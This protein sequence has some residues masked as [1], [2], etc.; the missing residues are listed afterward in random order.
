MD[1]IRLDAAGDGIC[2]IT[3]DRPAKRNA[4]SVAMRREFIRLLQSDVVRDARVLLLLAEGSVFSAGA[5]LRDPE[6]MDPRNVSLVSEMLAAL[7]NTRAV[8]I[9]AVQGPALGLGAGIAL[10]AD[11][12]ITSTAASFGFPE[13]Q[14]RL[15][16]TMTA[17]S[18][19]TYLAPRRAFELMITG[20]R[21]T[22]EQAVDFGLANRVVAPAELHAAVNDMAAKIVALDANAAAITKRFFYEAVEMPFAGGMRAAERVSELM[23]AYRHAPVQPAA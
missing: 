7:R 6:G 23:R 11:L 15:V 17:V 5:D 20:D 18:L 3:L 1:E 22:A 16:P 9:A 14:H 2:A 13:I 4:I 10:T 8:V 21:V 19:L 12:V